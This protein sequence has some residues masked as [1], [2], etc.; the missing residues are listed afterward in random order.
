M[1]GRS[2]GRA[3]DDELMNTL[4][5]RR[6]VGRT[7]EWDEALERRIMALTPAEVSAAVKKYID[8]KHTVIVR[9]GDFKKH[10]PEKLTP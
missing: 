8:L 9:A 6:F 3:N 7:L 1:Q 5:A 10:P 2:Q 4:I